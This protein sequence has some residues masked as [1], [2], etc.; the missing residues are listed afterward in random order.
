MA[1]RASAARLEL[2]SPVAT[3]TLDDAAGPTSDRVVNPAAP[4]PRPGT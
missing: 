2:P 4:R 3:T 1:A